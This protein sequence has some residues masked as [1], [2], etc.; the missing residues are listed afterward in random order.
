MTSRRM[1]VRVLK[2]CCCCCC[3]RRLCWWCCYPPFQMSAT[4][5]YAASHANAPCRPASV[6][7]IVRIGPRGRNGQCEVQL[8]RAE[9]VGR[10]PQCVHSQTVRRLRVAKEVALQCVA[11]SARAAQAEDLISATAAAEALRVA[12]T[13]AVG[14]KHPAAAGC[15]GKI[16]VV[17]PAEAVVRHHLPRSGVEGPKVCHRIAHDGL[18]L[19]ERDANGSLEFT[20]VVGARATLIRRYS[21]IAH[22]VNL[23]RAP[24]SR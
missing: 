9:V 22:R 13:R 5:R 24:L 18:R 3:C 4:W 14:S 21:A 12:D 20:G 19:C 8:W 2:C 7:A 10:V 15:S 16:T 17:A 11:S 23:F 6:G 1:E